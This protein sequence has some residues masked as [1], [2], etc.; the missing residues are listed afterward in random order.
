MLFV[1]VL[2]RTADLPSIESVRFAEC[3]LLCGEL[4]LFL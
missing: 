4:F 2:F 3:L 1:L